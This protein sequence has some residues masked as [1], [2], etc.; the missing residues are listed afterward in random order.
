MPEHAV[1]WATILPFGAKARI[2]AWA[3]QPPHD[4]VA[5]DPSMARWLFPTSVT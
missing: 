1:Q 3:T 4:G 5:N 2:A